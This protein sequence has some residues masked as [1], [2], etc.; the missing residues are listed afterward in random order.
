[1]IPL[2]SIGLLAKVVTAL[3]GWK[4]RR[5][6]LASKCASI[7]SGMIVSGTVAGAVEGDTDAA[8]FAGITYGGLMAIAKAIMTIV[9]VIRSR[10]K[11][12]DS[13]QE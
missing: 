11:E 3:R 13:G 5:S 1:M 6:M 4:A 7:A 8:V 9:R 10:R 2:K 12:A